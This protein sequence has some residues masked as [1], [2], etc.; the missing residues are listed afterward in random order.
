MWYVGQRVLIMDS[1]SEYKDYHG[2]ILE[3]LDDESALVDIGGEH[4]VVMLCDL[5]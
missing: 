3:L 1:K 5:G 2:V 4:V